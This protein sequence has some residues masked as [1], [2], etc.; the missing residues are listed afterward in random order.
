MPNISAA[1]PSISARA[2]AIVRG[3]RITGRTGDLR[4]APN[5]VDGDDDR[6]RWLT[7]PARSGQF[8]FLR[9]DGAELRRGTDFADAVEL[10][11][12]FV[13]AMERVGND[14][15]SSPE[16]AHTAS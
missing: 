3:L 15:N 13:A 7:L 4:S 10:Q 11:T 5:A 8:Y 6:E 12:G 1:S 2:A 16:S 9:P 14:K